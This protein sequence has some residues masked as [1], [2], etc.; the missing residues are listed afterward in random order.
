MPKKV[1]IALP[2][3]MLE[4]VDF[5]ANHEHRTRSDLIREA[6]RRYIAGFNGLPK[7]PIQILTEQ[8]DEQEAAQTA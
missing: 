1:L 3:R 4:E 6:L 5:I 2:P 8:E 7:R